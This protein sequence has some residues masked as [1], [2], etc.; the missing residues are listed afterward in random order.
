MNLKNII[1]SFHLD[2]TFISLILG[3]IAIYYK[4]NTILNISALCIL[5]SLIILG[6]LLTFLYNKTIATYYKTSRT[7]IILIN[8]LTHIVIPLY[9]LNKIIPSTDFDLNLKELLLV[10]ILCNSLIFGYFIFTR[11][12]Y[13]GS[14]GL[15]ITILTNLGIAAVFI[16]LIILYI[17]INKYYTNI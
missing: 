14:Y 6:N 4:N 3:Y 8:I 12:K 9:L 15:P 17:I 11:M 2:F 7:I 13:T 5:I 16:V 1:P 10:V